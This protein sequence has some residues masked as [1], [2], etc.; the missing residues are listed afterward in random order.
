MTIRVRMGPSHWSALAWSLRAALPH[1]RVNRCFPCAEF[2]VFAAEDGVAPGQRA[3]ARRAWP[4]ARV[5]PAD[6]LSIVPLGLAAGSRCVHCG[7]EGAGSGG[8]A[9]RAAGAKAA[10]AWG[11]HHGGAPTR[12]QLDLNQELHRCSSLEQILGVIERAKTQKVTPSTVNIIT[13]VN[14]IAKLRTPGQRP[15]AEELLLVRSEVAGH[16]AT[17][18]ETGLV[19]AL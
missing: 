10:R 8:G 9:E 13:A 14:K 17:C 4:R 7:E 15:R 18:D 2:A 1:G 5:L 16:S 19:Q 11:R 3:R 6:G 12:Q